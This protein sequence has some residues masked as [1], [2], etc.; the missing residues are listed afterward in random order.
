MLGTQLGWGKLEREQ[1]DRLGMMDIGWDAR[2]LGMREE[3]RFLEVIEKEER[4]P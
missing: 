1:A 4:K 2:F 3:A